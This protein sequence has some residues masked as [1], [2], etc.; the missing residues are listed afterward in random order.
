M[1]ANGG[2]EISFAPLPPKA[3]AA[4]R[5]ADGWQPLP[6]PR[7]PP[8]AHEFEHEGRRGS[9]VWVYR[10]PVGEPLFTTV[11]FDID[12]PETVPAGTKPR[13]NVVPFI[14]GQRKGQPVWRS[15]APDAPRPLYG[16][17]RLAARPD[18]PVV[19][20][21]GE[22]SAD[23]ATAI[24]RDMV[25]VT[26]QGGAEADA[27]ADWT[28]LRGRRVVIWPDNDSAG[29]KYAEAVRG[30]LQKVGAASIHTVPVPQ[31][32]P[33]GWD[34]ADAPPGGVTIE[35]LRD[36]ARVGA[37]DPNGLRFVQPPSLYGLPVPPRE[38]VVQDWLPIGAATLL[39]G[40]GGTGKTLLAQQLMTS[41][42]TGKPW[43]GLAVLPCR[44][45]ALFCEDDEAELHRRQDAIN[46]GYGIDFK[47]L[48]KMTWASGVG[49]DNALMRF[50]PDGGAQK[51][52]RCS[53]ILEAARRFDARL[54][55]IDTAAD[56]FGGNE[57][58]R[59]QVRNFLG[60]MNG[61][62]AELNAAV[63]V[64]AHP[65]KSGMSPTGDMDGGSTAWSNTARSRWSLTRPKVEDEDLRQSNERIL[66]RRKANYAAIGENIR[67]R[68]QNGV[69]EPIPA[70]NGFAAL[71]RNQDAESA[72][73]RLLAKSTTEGRHVSGEKSANNYAPK[74]FAGRPDCQDLSARD[75][76]AAME[77]LFADGRLRMEEYGRAGGAGG[78]KPRRLVAVDGGA[79]A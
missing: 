61:M 27:K 22:K 14:Y 34:V 72:F 55:I 24:F 6:P 67:L 71:V 31:D 51:Q 39:Y 58:D 66:T 56:T 35:Q 76:A 73:L 59:G 54:I 79:D 64:C 50:G 16:L 57:H 33:S 11:R 30:H 44:A 37:A 46:D 63:L 52:P 15:K 60:A 49:K 45:L 7:E 32:W 17:D 40:D 19:V 48:A 78:R 12:D 53:E 38:W 2:N 69:L 75:L 41:C 65:S 1:H 21:E 26:S 18:A 3:R 20:V 70:L 23:A 29:R 28:P 25:A 13:K 74:E 9:S 47:E 10:T 4:G 5:S 77:R 8:P 36:M 62:A 43:L 42:A 68:W